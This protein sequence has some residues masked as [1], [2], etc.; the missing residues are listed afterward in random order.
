MSRSVRLA[1]GAAEFNSSVMVGAN[2]E[3]QIFVCVSADPAAG[4]WE[5][6][7]VSFPW[8]EARRELQS[9]RGPV[10]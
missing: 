10:L 7:K 8:E 5:S 9:V 2:F 1:P 4:H 6:S 3:S